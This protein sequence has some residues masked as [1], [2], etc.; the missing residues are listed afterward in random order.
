M[1]QGWYGRGRD[2]VK[3]QAHPW[4]MSD[5]RLPARLGGGG[6]GGAIALAAT[7]NRWPCGAPVVPASYNEPHKRGLGTGYGEVAL[8]RVLTPR[9]G[10]DVA[11]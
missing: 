1:G 10:R 8:G 7:P 9:L 5:Q 2:R 11:P 6:G 3:S 4:R